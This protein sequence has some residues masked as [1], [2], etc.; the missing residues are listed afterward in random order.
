MADISFTQ[1]FHH[2]DWVDDVDR[3]R[4]AEPNG[5]NARFT[6]IEADLQQLS[7]VVAQI[8]GV[9]NHAGSTQRLTLPAA[10]V[11]LEGATPWFN[12]SNGTVFVPPGSSASGL[13]NVA[14]PNGVT[15]LAFRAFGRATGTTVSISLS[16]VPIGGSTPQVLASV[17]G[18][19]DPFNR[20]ALIDPVAAK[21]ATATTRFLIQATAPTTPDTG[22]AFASVSAFQITYSVD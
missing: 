10:L 4:A 22:T 20:V 12:D 18:D 3:V 11:P 14:L 8:D 2:T 9:L 5:F 6:A 7:A 17:S 13:L 1:T 21:T 15:L 16:R 19:A